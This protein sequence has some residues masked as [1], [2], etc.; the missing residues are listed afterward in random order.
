MYYLLL[1]LVYSDSLVVVVVVVV[2]VIYIRGII[3]SSKWNDQRV[4]RFAERLSKA[5]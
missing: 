5:L 1:L 3:T 4:L 2:V